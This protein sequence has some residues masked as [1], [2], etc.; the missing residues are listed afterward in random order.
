MRKPILTPAGIIVQPGVYPSPDGRW[1][2]R[3]VET[4]NGIITYMVTDPAGTRTV[5][6]DGGFST[7]HRWFFFWDQQNQL[8]TYNSDMGPFGTWYES[9]DGKWYRSP[10]AGGASRPGAVPPQVYEALPDRL[11]KGFTPTSQPA[12]M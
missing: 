2:L 11:K 6:S 7:Y 9:P 10:V 3:V 5:V 12:S 4:R 8:W 1:I